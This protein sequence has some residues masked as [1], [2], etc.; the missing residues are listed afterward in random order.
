MVTISHYETPLG[1]TKKWNSWAD[2]RTIDC[3]VRYCETIFNRY[4]DKVKYWMTFNEI[5]CIELGS[6]M[7]GGVIARR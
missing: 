4:K 3:Y 1:L 2:R 5:N 7:A 6:Y